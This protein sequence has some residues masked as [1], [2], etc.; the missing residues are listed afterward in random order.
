ML[1]HKLI[2]KNVSSKLAKAL[3]SMYAVVKSCV[4][5]KNNISDYMSSDIGL[6]QGDPSSPLM[7]MMFINDL[8]QNIN[9]DIGDLFTLND[10][11]LFMLL[12]ADDAVVFATSPESL[13]LLLCDIETYCMTWGLKI[14]TTKTKIMIFERGRPTHFNFI[15][16]NAII[17][18]VESFK[19]LG[20]HFL[21]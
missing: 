19:Y 16:N 11:K 5:Y 17:E 8:G 15:L 12:Y 13:Q 20:I 14:N 1:W 10:I 7:F 4:R 9:T 18:V 6:K 2:T 3:K 21:D